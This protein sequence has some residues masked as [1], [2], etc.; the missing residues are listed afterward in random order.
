MP[1]CDHPDIPVQ[2]I[3][4]STDSYLEKL[5]ILLRSQ[6]PTNYKT[7]HQDTG[8]GMPSFIHGLMAEHRLTIKGGFGGDSMHATTL[9]LGDILI[10]L[11]CGT[12]ECAPTDN[13][14]LWDW[15]VLTGDVW[16]D[17]GRAV[18]DARPY[19][20][21]SFDRPP[22][23]IAE[24]CNSGY[25][26]KEWQGYLFGLAPALLY[27][28]LPHPYWQNFCHL[29]YALRILLQRVITRR[30]L[31][32]S[33]NHL[34]MFQDGFE[35]LYLQRRTDRLHIHRPC[36]HACVHMGP[37][38]AR[39]GPPILYSTW[40]MERTIG[41][42]GAEIRQPSNPYANLS[43]RSILRARINA[44]K[45]M[46]PSFNVT[47]QLAASSLDLGDGYV[48]LHARERSGQVREGIEGQAIEKYLRDV[49]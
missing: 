35:T 15:A 21:G 9:N 12:F 34:D 17:H 48:L 3:N 18:A 11:W 40:T 5:Q 25:K 13:Y 28:V 26:A 10:P 19:I 47:T 23:N 46:D 6:N 24:K 36:I 16:K 38:V 43:Q 41:D 7:R 37:E 22:R 4:S 30:Q 45:A 29:V 32:D 14:E 2:S 27:N 20:P 31:Q 8:I 42:L 1:G 39:L 49:E 44:L 33:Q